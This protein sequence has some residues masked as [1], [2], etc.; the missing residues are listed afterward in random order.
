LEKGLPTD[1]NLAVNGGRKMK[2]IIVSTFAGLILLTLSFAGLLMDFDVQGHRGCR[3]LYP[4]NTLAGFRYAM[5]TVGVDTIELDVGISKDLIL[6]VNHDTYLN[7]ERTMK[8][9]S[10][11]SEKIYIKDLTLEQ[12]KTYSVG[13]I[14]NRFSFFKQKQLNEEPIPT[15]QE[16]IDLVISFNKSSEKKIKMNIETKI[17]ALEPHQTY[18]SHIFV[19][20]LLEIIE[21]NNIEE[22]VSIQS[23]YWKPIMDIKKQAPQIRTVALLSKTRL[24]DLEWFNGIDPEDY[25]SFAE[26]IKASNADCLSMNYMDISEQQIFD[27]QSLGIKVIPYTINDEATMRRFISLGVNGIITDYPDVLMTVLETCQ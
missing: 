6:V 13:R 2:K 20:L 17:D 22:V 21:K 19:N 5:E 7:P 8:D 26:F 24:K 12:I 4:E 9:G 16:V 25:S 1:S 11:I 18:E 15:L 23:F 14:Q 10:F 27:V 3:G